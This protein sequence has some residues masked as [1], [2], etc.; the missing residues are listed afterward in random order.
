MLLVNDHAQVVEIAGYA[1]GDLAHRHLLCLAKLFKV[2]VVGD[3]V[4]HT[5]QPWRDGNGGC[6]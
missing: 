1:P 4:E 3:V 2:L 5:L 6:V